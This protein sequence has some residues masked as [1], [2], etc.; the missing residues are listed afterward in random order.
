MSLIEVIFGYSAP[1]EPILRNR[2]IG[3]ITLQRVGVVV[4]GLPIALGSA[5]LAGGKPND[6][7]LPFGVIAVWLIVAAMHTMNDII[8]IERDKKK[9]PNRPLP[10]GLIPRW[11]AVIYAVVMA[12]IGII[13]AYLVFN[14]LCAALALMVIVL[15]CIYTRY[16]RD[17]IGFLTLVWIPAFEPVGAW[18]AIS[19]GTVLTPLPWMLYTFLAI[20]QVAMMMVEDF[21][22]LAP[23]AKVFFIKL[24]ARTERKIYI[25]AVI[26]LFLMGTYI[27]IYAKLHIFYMLVLAAL[28]AW[29]INSAKYLTGQTI[30]NVKKAFVMITLYNVI[31]WSCLG[32]SALIT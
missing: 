1:K 25:A 31:Y 26:A 27:F 28:T 20:H 15:G 2:I 5:A 10:S 19:P 8:D 17:K 3:L 13:M 21:E 9:F 30:D 23:G 22:T 11:V 4:M 18:A 24:S 6:P 14:W 7:R 12:G 16:T 32:L 29:G